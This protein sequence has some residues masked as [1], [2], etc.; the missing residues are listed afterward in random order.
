MRLDW[1]HWIA[2]V[3]T[4]LVPHRNVSHVASAAAELLV[5]HV[6]VAA[7]AFLQAW[8]GCNYRATQEL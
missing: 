2:A 7:S 4:K 5:T 1:P 8:Y 6:L 3:E